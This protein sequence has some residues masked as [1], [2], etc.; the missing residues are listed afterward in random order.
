MTYLRR[1]FPNLRALRHIL[2]AL[3]PSIPAVAVVLC[4]R[5]SGVAGGGI[6]DEAVLLV[7]YGAVTVAATWATERDLVAEV[8]GYLRRRPAAGAA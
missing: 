6:V 3:V 4:A 1:L 7:L 8:V 2:R 5:A